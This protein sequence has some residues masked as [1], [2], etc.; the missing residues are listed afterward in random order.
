MKY[1]LNS[2]VITSPGSY[3]YRLVSADQAREWAG[4]GDVL[5]TI[6]YAQTAEALAQILDQK[7]EVNRIQIKMAL[8]DEALVFRLVFPAGAP[9]INPGDKGRL[10]QA[11]IDGRYEIG[12]LTRTA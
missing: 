12:M 4:E 8:G 9:R 5:S 7:V 2:A 11:V 6:G 10:A 3:E 1:L